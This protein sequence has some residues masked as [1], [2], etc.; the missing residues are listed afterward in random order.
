VYCGLRV[1]CCVC[2]VLR[3]LR[4]TCCVYCMSACVL[5][6]AVCSAC[7][8]LYCVCLAHLIATCVQAQK[9]ENEKRGVLLN[10]VHDVKYEA[11]CIS[12]VIVNFTM[13]HVFIWISA[14]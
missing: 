10:T 14:S 11:T 8:M 7:C 3:V 4:V 6:D 9:K 13:V 5:L 2:C 12:F 1:A